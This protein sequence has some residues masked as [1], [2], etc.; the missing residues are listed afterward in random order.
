MNG[1]SDLAI[2]GII[3]ALGIGTWLIR[4]SFLG[5]VGDRDLPPW[6][7]R[8]LRYTPVAVLPALLAPLL[9]WPESTGGT[10]DPPRLVAAAMTVVVGL[11]TRS[12]LWAVA[13]GLG[14]FFSLQVLF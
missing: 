3:A 5:L 14:T 7:L 6:V 9:V 11:Y 12:I 8:H 1:W 2:W 4:F 10:F 13:S